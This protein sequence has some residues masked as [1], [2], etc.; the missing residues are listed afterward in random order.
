LTNAITKSVRT[1]ILYPYWELSNLPANCLTELESFSEFWA[2]TKFIQ[3]MLKPL[4]K[5]V[6]LIPQPV[7]IPS[8]KSLSEYQR[9]EEKL[10][11]LTFFS[12]DSIPDR[13]N[14]MAAVK[15]F[16]QAFEQ[17]K[18]V[19]LIVKLTGGDEN[20]EI[21]KKLQ[22]VANSDTRITIIDK[23]LNRLEVEQLVIQCDVF[24]SL[25]RSEGFGFGPAEALAAA[26]PVI[27]T[28]YG[29]VTD[30]INPE[31]AYPVGFNLI[32]VAPGKYPS[33]ENQ[34][35]AEPIIDDAIASLKE[36]KADPQAATARGKSGREWMVKNHGIEAIGN[37]IAG[38]Y[39][40]KQ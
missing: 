21:R 27:T 9:D 1:K 14:P 18:D 24:I 6:T 20:H 13:R 10:T 15:A 30:F 25:H 12:V 35:W 33:W 19:Q 37:L 34:V 26:K 29:G 7:K 22:M 3:D 4:G 11:V 38:Y 28:S 8:S 5:K 2:P 16:Q 17:D 40:S 39:F 36:I 31:T 32:G 23:T